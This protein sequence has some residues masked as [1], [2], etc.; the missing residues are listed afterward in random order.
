MSQNAFWFNVIR[1]SARCQFAE[2]RGIYVI[3][4]SKYIYVV[5]HLQPAL[6]GQ[7]NADVV[8]DE[9]SLTPCFKTTRQENSHKVSSLN[10]S[11]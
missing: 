1:L 5:L 11:V 3:L 10:Q 8:W 2:C 6:W 4:T 7:Q 9:M